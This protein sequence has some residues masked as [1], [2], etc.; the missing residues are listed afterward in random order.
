MSDLV[1]ILKTWI[2]NNNNIE[3]NITCAKLIGAIRG[4]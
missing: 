1:K 3:Y 2:T 4:A